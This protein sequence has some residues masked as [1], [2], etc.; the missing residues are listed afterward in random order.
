MG[1]LINIPGA[2]LIVGGVML[3]TE[4]NS[5]I[6][7]AVGCGLGFTYLLAAAVVLTT[8]KQIFLA[9]LYYYAVQRQVPAGFTAEAMKGAFQRK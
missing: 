5:I 9:G 4:Y 2:L 6:P 1:L 7:V 3:G 8:V